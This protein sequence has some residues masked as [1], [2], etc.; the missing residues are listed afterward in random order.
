MKTANEAEVRTIHPEVIKEI[1]MDVAIELL[2][3]ARDL[4]D[5]TIESDNFDMSC[6]MRYSPCCGTVC[7]IAGWVA[8]RMDKRAEELFMTYTNKSVPGL[9]W[10]VSS[11][12]HNRL[13]NLC[14][15]Q[16]PSSPPLAADAIERY[17]YDYAIAPWGKPYNRFETILGSE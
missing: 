17:V 1:G 11:D 14:N 3:V 10:K 9:E 16:N 4:R 15:G 13:L 12:G 8:H 7:C 6:I 5:G 2:G